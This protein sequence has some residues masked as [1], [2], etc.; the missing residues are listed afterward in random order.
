M[1]L[2]KDIKLPRRTIQYSL[3]LLTKKGFLQKTGKGAGS[4]YQ[5][6]F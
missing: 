3:N 6:I 5:L 4:R 2:E 1:E